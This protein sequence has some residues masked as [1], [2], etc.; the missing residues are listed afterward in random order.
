[1]GF[2]VFDFRRFVTVT[3]KIQNADGTGIINLYSFNQAPQGLTAIYV[4]QNDAVAHTVRLSL[5]Q[6]GENVSIGVATVPAGAGANNIPPVELLH[7]MGLDTVLP[8]L[9]GEGGFVFLNVDTAMAAA[10][11]LD[12]VSQVGLF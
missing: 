5:S 11:E 7:S 8:F 10:T 3:A 6:S 2:G 1:V 4:Q 12:A 9:V